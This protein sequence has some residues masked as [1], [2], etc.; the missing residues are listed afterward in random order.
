MFGVSVPPLRAPVKHGAWVAH[1]TQYGVGW[2]RHISLLSTH[3]ST[4]QHPPLHHVATQPTSQP[5]P[6]TPTSGLS[7]KAGDTPNSS[8]LNLHN[9]LNG[10]REKAWAEGTKWAQSQPGQAEGGQE[11][12]ALPAGAQGPRVVIIGPTDA[13]GAAHGLLMLPQAV[14][15]L[16]AGLG[17]GVW[18]S[19]GT[20]HHYIVAPPLPAL[21]LRALILPP[22]S[23]CCLRQIHPGQAAGELGCSQPVRPWEQ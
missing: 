20:S 22:H 8:Y 13:G 23:Q 14:R 2:H 15:Q 21:C 17:V 3:G 1:T 10:L 12:P 11:A 16:C 18:L 19:C 9:S 6:P 5:H 4:H 7:Y